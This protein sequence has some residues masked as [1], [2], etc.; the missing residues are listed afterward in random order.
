MSLPLSAGD[1]GSFD[2]Y[3]LILM[4]IHHKVKGFPKLTCLWP[5]AI[6]LNSLYLPGNLC[7]TK[8]KTGKQAFWKKKT[9]KC[10]ISCNKPAC[11]PHLYLWRDDYGK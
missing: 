7:Y 9:G 6:F 11:N 1:A 8:H 2:T 3:I 5:G 4:N 10:T